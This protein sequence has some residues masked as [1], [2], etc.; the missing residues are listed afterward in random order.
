MKK[1]INS[2][3]F[4]ETKVEPYNGIYDATDSRY[5]LDYAYRVLADHARMCSVCIAD[6][7][8]PQTK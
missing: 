3:K 2:L 8:Y 7:M 6:G 5:N 1:K 4:Q